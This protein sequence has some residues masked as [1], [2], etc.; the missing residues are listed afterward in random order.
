MTAI[1]TANSDEIDVRDSRAY[2]TQLKVVQNL[3][4]KEDVSDEEVREK[5][6]NGVE[7]LRSVPTAIY[8]FLRAQAPIQAIE[9]DNKVRRAMQY[10]ISLGGDTDTIA[11]MAGALAGAYLGYDNINKTLQAHCEGIDLIL[12]LAES[13]HHITPVQK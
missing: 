8:C 9:T 10:S 5:L 7:A 6:G 3:L 2:E 12:K 4:M 13:L 11:T 1:E